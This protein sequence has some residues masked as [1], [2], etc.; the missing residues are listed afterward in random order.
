MVTVAVSMPMF[1]IGAT[2]VSLRESMGFASDGIGLAV[3]VFHGTGAFVAVWMGRLVDRIGSIWSVRFAAAGAAVTSFCVAFLADGLA[4]LLAIMVLGGAAAMLAQP[5]ANR[6]LAFGVPPA[7]QGVAFGVKQSA[8]P[9]A[10]MLAGLSIPLVVLTWGWQTAYL[11]A[12]LL[13]AAV[14][15]LAGPRPPAAV[16]APRLRSVRIP[17]EDR[18]TLMWLSGAIGLAAASSTAAFS[19]YVDG[20][21]AAGTSHERAGVMLA[22]A[23]AASVT[24]RLCCG[25]AADRMRGDRLR[26]CVWLLWIGVAGMVLLAVGG[27]VTMAAGVAVALAG[28]WGVNGLFWYVV[29]RG[30]TS[31]PGRASGSVMQGL[32]VGA[33]VGPFVFGFVTRI[34]GMRAAWIVAAVLA[35]GSALAMQRGATRLRERAAAAHGVGIT[36][37]GAVSDGGGHGDGNPGS[38]G[39]TTEADPPAE[40]RDSHPRNIGQGER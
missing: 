3:A 33:T 31:S 21:V 20:A 16:R 34:A 17:R 8:P 6:L 15:V 2:S 18:R 38:S 7:R 12:G 37:S 13:A 28:T 27:R 22:V 29:M 26:L 24:V 35:T 5:A 19:F 30:F 4:S 11:M 9:V 36:G 1:L 14:V 23:G 40:T 32:L 39:N 25:F 10:S